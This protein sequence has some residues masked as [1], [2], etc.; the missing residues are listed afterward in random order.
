MKIWMSDLAEAREN[1]RI[2]SPKIDKVEEGSELKITKSKLL[3]SRNKLNRNVIQQPQLL[4]ISDVFDPDDSLTV[5]YTTS[6]WLNDRNQEALRKNLSILSVNR[7]NSSENIKESIYSLSCNPKLL[8]YKSQDSNIQAKRIISKLNNF[9]N[10]SLNSNLLKSNHNLLQFNIRD[11][12]LAVNSVSSSLI[13]NTNLVS[14]FDTNSYSKHT[15]LNL[16]KNNLTDSKF[17]EYKRR[18]NEILARAK[19]IHEAK[20]ASEPVRIAKLEDFE[21]KKTL[22]TGR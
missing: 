15:D 10:Q 3:D 18:W 21:L 6:T 22:G 12:Q 9:N 17:I 7:I 4:T 16:H 14:Y 2:Q 8:C 1:D 5:H 11:R 13:K 20:W 19:I